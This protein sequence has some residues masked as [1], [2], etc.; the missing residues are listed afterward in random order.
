MGKRN[1]K[2]QPLSRYSYRVSR[3]FIT[4]KVY[5]GEGVAGRGH[6]DAIY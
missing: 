4:S 2:R 1:L 5:G 3:K 6:E